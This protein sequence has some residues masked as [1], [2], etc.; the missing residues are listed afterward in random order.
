M[1]NE[2]LIFTHETQDDYFWIEFVILYYLPISYIAFG[3]EIL[4]KAVGNQISFFALMFLFALAIFEEIEDWQL[5]N[6]FLKIG[7][8]I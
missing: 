2:Y 3:L 5:C 1:V 4:I 7:V 8:G 6:D